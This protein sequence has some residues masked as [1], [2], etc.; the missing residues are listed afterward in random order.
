MN[1]DDLTDE[2]R[3]A[4]DVARD[5]IA[6]GVPVRVAEPVVG[7][8]VWNPKGGTGGTGYTLPSRWQQSEPYLAELDAWRPG[9]A[10]FAVMGHGVDLL[11]VDPRNGGD[12]TL[13]GWAAGDLIPQ[14]Y[15]TASTPS[16]G[17]HYL[18]KSLE[19]GSKD[20]IAPGVDIK[21][22]KPDGSSRGFMFLAPTVK[23]S[24]VTG[25][26]V[27]YRW[28]VDPFLD[29]LDD[30]DD[31]GAWLAAKIT[32]SRPAQ[33]VHETT[34]A[35]R[36]EFDSLPEPE[37]ARVRAYLDATVKGMTEDLAAIVAWPKGR[38]DERG[39]GWQ[40]I[41]ADAAYRLGSLARAP[42]SPWSMGD[43]WELFKTMLPDR[44]A[45]CVPPTTEWA[46]QS[47]RKAPAP[48][49]AK[50]DE[51]AL[52]LVRT[53]G[54]VP[55]NVDP[56]T[57]E[58]LEP[59]AD[60]DDKR[61]ASAASVLVDLA[62]QRY[63]FGVSEDGSP[64]GVKA[65]GSHV[66]RRLRGGRQSFRAE[67]A[68]AYRAKTG[69]VAAQQALADALQVIE[70]DAQDR[71]PE[72][73]HL[74]VAEHADAVWIDMGDATERVV[75]VDADG[76]TITKTAP[77]LFTRTELTA[78]MVTPE[79]GGDVNELF[80][81][82]NVAPVDR[83]LIVAWLVSVLGAPGIPHPILALMGEQGTGKSTAAR[84]LVS[85]TDPAAVPLRPPPRD[86]DSWITAAQ[87]SWVIGLD[88][89]SDVKDWFSDSLCRAVTG[90]GNVK[91]QLYTD[92]QLAVFKF[93]RSILLNGIDL[94]GLRGDL[95]ERLLTVQL[96][97]I[98]ASARRTERELNREWD[99]A[100][101]RILGGLLDE[102]AGMIR[103]LPFAHL[104]SYPRMAD[105]AKVAAAVGGEDTV[106][107]YLDQGGRL[108]ADSLSSDPFMAR[109]LETITEP[110]EGTAAEL[111]DLVTDPESRT[112]AGWPRN[113]RQVTTEL[114]R[115][116]PAM[117]AQGWTVTDLGNRNK[118]GVTRWQVSPLQLAR[119]SS[120]PSPPSPPSPHQ[121]LSDAF[122]QAGNRRGTGG[123]GGEQGGLGGEGNFGSPPDSD[124]I[125]P[126]QPVDGGQ[127]GK[128]GK[129]PVTTPRA[130]PSRPCP[131]CGNDLATE[132][133]LTERCRAKHAVRKNA[134]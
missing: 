60:P 82:I 40:K 45:A 69:K 93:R 97:R 123:L 7:N 132:Y 107:R 112:P 113:A 10:L 2:Q 6:H 28:E 106:T 59:P 108:A 68:T 95:S 43:A 77:V 50:R 92:G 80:D 53:K 58:V 57:G 51:P 127:A 8:G 72:Q 18:I 110:F 37:Q 64:F 109:V 27:A 23:L 91:R 24:K 38:T 74:R 39:R 25:E 9:C 115:N 55:A 128:A 98:D 126:S 63:R 99:T 13:A 14:T 100:R 89:L 19:V 85:L 83:P 102:V 125:A 11:D 66:V 96:E 118:N 78:P 52:T 46:A 90:D 76:W 79:R 30:A 67:L 33:R 32:A 5:L 34:P 44:V 54:E 70:G 22:G 49:P 116:G 4:L 133:G 41:T 48:F 124:T 73:V 15:G 1:R 3:H 35:D 62:Q 56:N 84:L 131:D 65:D 114:R 16:G 26:P 81:F 105:F 17:Q 122:E 119:Q 20:G 87:G 94:G 29:D 104:G 117:V 71:D 134:A 130:T 120:P 31:T 111:L 36:A 75:K 101:G 121:P 61:A 21:S 86:M 129:N 47:R 42:W 12:E 88:N 103:H